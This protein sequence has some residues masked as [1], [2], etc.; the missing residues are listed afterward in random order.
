LI[1][2]INYGQ[3]TRLRSQETALR[4]DIGPLKRAPKLALVADLEDNSLNGMFVLS[5]LAAF[6]RSVEAGARR[7][8]RLRER[9][10]IIPSI[11][12]LD[13]AIHTQRSNEAHRPTA[14][15]VREVV[16]ALTRTAYYRVNMRAVNS[17]IEE[18]P[19][20]LLYA[21]NDDERASAC[22][23]GLPAVIEQ[24]ADAE[25]AGDLVRSWQPY[26]GENF[27]IRAGQ[28]GNL[29][30]RHCEMLFRALVAF[31]GRTGIIDGLQLVEG[32]EDLHYFD[33]RQVRDAWAESSGVFTS[34]LEV[35]RWVRAGEELGQIH[36]GF[37]GD[38]RARVI[39]PVAGLLAGLRRQ[40]LLCAGD[41]VARILALDI[42]FRRGAARRQSG[43]QYHERQAG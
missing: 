27:V 19:Q 34:R 20:V 10:V 12:A 13:I 40:P 23:F 14:A 25:E 11:D 7:E 6:L 8:L 41:L 1:N 22:L 42:P 36:D 30:T 33:P 38:I 29:Q 18:M 28:P 24:P 35:G 16:M 32:E 21:P 5:R 26:R 15:V 2:R 9:V 3:I 43:G 37:T 31:L 4:P 39:A 17:D